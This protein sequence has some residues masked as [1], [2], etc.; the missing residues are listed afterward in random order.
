MRYFLHIASLG[1]IGG[2]DEVRAQAGITESSNIDYLG[3][4]AISSAHC[5]T[6]E[7]VF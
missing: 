5:V 7:L 3:L 1:Q 4:I 6:Y 2:H